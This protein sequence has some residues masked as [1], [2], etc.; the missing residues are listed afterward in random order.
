MESTQNSSKISLHE[1]GTETQQ[2]RAA[3][4]VS[5]ATNIDPARTSDEEGGPQSEPS[6]PGAKAGISVKRFWVIMFGF[7]LVPALLQRIL[8]SSIS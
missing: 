4:D 8:S 7:V 6:H 1:I 3:K 5:E 2:L